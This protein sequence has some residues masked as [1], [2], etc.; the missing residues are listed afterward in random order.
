M[1]TPLINE[2]HE[3]DLKMAAKRVEE[4]SKLKAA[5]IAEDR[6]TAAERLEMDKLR[7][8]TRMAERRHADKLEADAVAADRLEVDREVKRRRHLN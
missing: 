4:R 7:V 8:K 2:H 6:R 1:D 5:I 3:F